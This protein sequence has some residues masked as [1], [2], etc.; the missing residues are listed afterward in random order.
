MLVGMPLL[1]VF[2]RMGCGGIILSTTGH[3]LATN[4]S[5][6][7]ILQQ[8]FELD[9]TTVAALNG[10]GREIIK[11]LLG[12][13][14]TR[15]CLD[16]ENWILIERFGQ[17][18]LIMNC[19]PVPVLS[20]DGPHTVLLLIDLD[21]APLPSTSCLEQIFSLTPA[22]A[23]LA[24]LLVGSKTLA[25]VAEMLHLSIATVR[26]QLRAVFEKTHTHRQAEL[27][28]LVSRLAALP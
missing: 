5:A 22:E 20:E 9:E 4:A 26:T 8:M 27:V 12:L 18:P 25:E 21:V 6:R 23:R 16:S 7:L 28:V 1:R 10:S 24:L 11:R 14:Q 15:I 3:V 2:D 13:G 17:R 19:V